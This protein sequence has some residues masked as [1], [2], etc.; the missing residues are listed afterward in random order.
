MIWLVVRQKVEILSLLMYADEGVL[1]REH[2]K[3]RQGVGGTVR[4]RVEHKFGGA[5]F[6]L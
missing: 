4:G 6:K 1:M 5:K 3:R 2:C